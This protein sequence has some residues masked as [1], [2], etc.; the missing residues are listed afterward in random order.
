MEPA[1]NGTGSVF[2]SCR[3]VAPLAELSAS[4]E[5]FMRLRVAIAR[6][7]YLQGSLTECPF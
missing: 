1:N 7:T 3:T 5:I 6:P 2:I 4:K